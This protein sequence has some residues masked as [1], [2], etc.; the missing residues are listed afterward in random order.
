MKI[1]S[2]ASLSQ[3]SPASAGV[4][5]FFGAVDEMDA[6]DCETASSFRPADGQPRDG[7]NSGIKVGGA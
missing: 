3:L 2:C 6:A 1:D 4:P 5:E 7:S